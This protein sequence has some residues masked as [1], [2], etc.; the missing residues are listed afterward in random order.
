MY[1]EETCFYYLRTRYYDPYIGRFLNADGL[2]QNGLSNV[3][4]FAYC[5]NNPV[6]YGDFTGYDAVLLV[7]KDL[8]GH[9]GILIQDDDGIW[10]HFYWGASKISLRLLLGDFV[11]VRTW[12]KEINVPIDVNDKKRTLKNIN[13]TG[14]FNGKYDDMIY[15]IG[16]FSES[17][18]YAF[19]ITSYNGQ[20]L[21]SLSEQNC[22]QVS[23]KILGRSY[24][25]YSKDLC[26]AALHKIPIKGFKQFKTA[27]AIIDRKER[28]GNRS[29]YSLPRVPIPIVQ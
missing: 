23:F 10:Y 25:K 7:D 24:T 6:M 5:R 12:L 8:C 1:D 11:K 28:I 20:K 26:K 15:L 27:K 13:G 18:D 16:D 21:Y 22:S 9:I 19:E 3:N 4:L 14:Q 17:V 29:G 2:I